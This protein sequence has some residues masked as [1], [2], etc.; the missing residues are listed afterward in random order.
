MVKRLLVQIIPDDMD[1]SDSGN[2]FVD[3]PSSKNSFITSSEAYNSEVV[4]RIL[5]FCSNGTYALITDFEWYIK[6]LVALVKV[7]RI[8]M[9]S[10]ISTQLIDVTLRV[11]VREFSVSEMTKLI[12]DKS[13]LESANISENNSD[14]LFAAAWI[15]GEYAE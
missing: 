4:S 15:I 8:S 3:K 11:N 1:A 7:P 14:C 9:G 2:H 5:S 12:M 10:L 13:L 6:V